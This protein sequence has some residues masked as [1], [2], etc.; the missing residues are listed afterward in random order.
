MEE[1][2]IDWE[3][4]HFQIPPTKAMDISPI[5]TDRFADLYETTD[6][7]VLRKINDVPTI[8]G[9][10]DDGFVRHLTAEEEDK[11]RQDGYTVDDYNRRL[12]EAKFHKLM[13]NSTEPLT[14]RNGLSFRIDDNSLVYTVI[15][16]EWVCVG[17][18]LLGDEQLSELKPSIIRDLRR[19]GIDYRFSYRWTLEPRPE[20]MPYR[21]VDDKTYY[22]ITSPD[23]LKDLIVY[24]MNDAFVAIG[25]ILDNKVRP[26]SSKPPAFILYDND[27]EQRDRVNKVVHR[28][29]PATQAQLQLSWVINS[30]VYYFTEVDGTKFLTRHRRGKIEFVGC[31]GRHYVLPA[32]DNQLILGLIHGFTYVDDA[33]MRETFNRTRQ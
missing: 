12:E 32:T 9:C 31:L 30:I 28:A 19:S 26:L 22:L 11:L 20:I 27:S 25:Q 16:G 6:G 24:K 4:H 2:K 10:W 5:S 7:L 17:I 33:G 29:R 3:M 23:S 1:I 8:V 14:V 18:S 15:E 21:T 13:L